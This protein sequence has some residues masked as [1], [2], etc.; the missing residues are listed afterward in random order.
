MTKSPLL[1]SAIA[2]AAATFGPAASADFMP[3]E[4][5]NATAHGGDDPGA[6]MFSIEFNRAPDFFTLDPLGNQQDAFQLL[7]DTQPGGRGFMPW[8]SIIRGSE[9]HVEGDVRVRDATL[10]PGPRDS[11]GGGWGPVVDTLPYML[12]GSKIQFIAPFESIS[13]EDDLFTYDMLTA[14]YGAMSWFAADVPSG[15][16][17]GVVDGAVVVPLPAAVLLGFGGLGAVIVASRTRSRRLAR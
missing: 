6:I 15:P 10:P 13:T 14:N 11:D 5:V 8:E 17:A 3:L 2:I 7:L 1:G 4:V 9:I 16:Q 12:E